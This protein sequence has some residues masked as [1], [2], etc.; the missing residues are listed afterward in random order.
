M[1]TI[2]LI[3]HAKSSW[4]APSLNDFERPLNKRGTKDA[5]CIGKKLAQLNFNPE[6]IISSSSVRTRKTIALICNEVAYNLNEVVY[7]D[8]LFHASLSTLKKN[9]NDTNNKLDSI[10]IVGHNF[11]ISNFANYL[12][13]DAVGTMPTCA[14]V[15]ITLDVDSWEEIIEGL[16]N[17]EYYIYPKMLN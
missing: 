17:L 1:K 13:A 12:T 2:F 11:G 9:I 7:R 14:V 5:P 3:R 10:A 8:E 4:S 6:L 15:K 16:G